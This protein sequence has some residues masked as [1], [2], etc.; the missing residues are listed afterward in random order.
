M[1]NASTYI[2]IVSFQVAVSCDNN[3]IVWSDVSISISI[4]MCVRRKETGIK[5]E[6]THL[7]QRLKKIDGVHH[8]DKNVRDVLLDTI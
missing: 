6:L 1:S 4:L 2:G 7:L 5:D 8:A 3:I